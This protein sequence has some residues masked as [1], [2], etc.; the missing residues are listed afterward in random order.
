MDELRKCFVCKQQ[1]PIENFYKYRKTKY[2]RD[3]KDCFNTAGKK[4]WEEKKTD[5]DWKANRKKVAREY[6]LRNHERFL[7]AGAKRRAKEKGIPFSITKDDIVI[8]EFCP[9]LGIPI[10]RGPGKACSNSPSIDEIVQGKGY[11]PGNIEVMSYKANAMKN[12]ATIPELV[13]FAKK[14]LE[15]FG[16]K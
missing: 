7:V 6:L 5:A 8:P 4:K 10:T 1:V 13:L 11:V 2:F 9:Y 3:C 12:N 15:K 14:V 16:D